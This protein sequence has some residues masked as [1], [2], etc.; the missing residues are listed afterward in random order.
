[1]TDPL[2][3][4]IEHRIAEAGY[5]TLKAFA[6]KSGIRAGTLASWIRGKSRP[7]K[8]SLEKLAVALQ[9]RVEDFMEKTE[10]ADAGPVG[11]DKDQIIAKLERLIELQNRL[12]Q[13]LE[14]L[15]AHR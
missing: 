10:K 15:L 11:E 6:E 8:K 7:S 12:I 9:C 2:I 14:R 4:N 1:M 5:P 3:Q 13:K